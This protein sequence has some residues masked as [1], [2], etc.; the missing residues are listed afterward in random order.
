MAKRQQ[1]DERNRSIIPV[2]AKS[3]FAGPQDYL[4]VFPF[5]GRIDRV[6]R[7]DREP[8]ETASSGFVDVSEFCGEDDLLH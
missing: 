1:P 4:L 2:F 6:D 8:G 7:I 3:P 5:G